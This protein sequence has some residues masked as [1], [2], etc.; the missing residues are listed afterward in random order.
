MPEFQEIIEIILD[1]FPNMRYIYHPRSTYREIDR[2]FFIDC[3]GR[4]AISVADEYPSALMTVISKDGKY[5]NDLRV[6][7]IE[8]NFKFEQGDKEFLIDRY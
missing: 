8:N 2:G 7:F 3:D 6:L 4:K 1:A 5:W